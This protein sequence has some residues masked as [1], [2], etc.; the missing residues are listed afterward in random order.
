M[1]LRGFGSDNHA[2]IHPKILEGIL[3]ANRDH[4]AS[5]GTDHL[6]EKTR[7]LFKQ[8]F[9]ADTESFFVFNGT[10]ANVLSFRALLL[11][12]EAIIASDTAHAA[13]DE[14]SAPEFHGGN[15]IITIKSKDGKL[16][17]DLIR[18]VLIR[19]GDQHAAQPRLV[20]LTQPTEWGTVYSL[21]ELA[22]L[23]SFAKEHDLLIHLDG[24]RLA[25][26][27]AHL[28][29]TFRDLVNVAKPAAISFG[30][31]KN[32]LMGAEAVLFFS[33]EFTKNFKYI[34]KQE[35]QLHSKTRF[36]AA[37]LFTYLQDGF[38]Y[39][40][41]QKSLHLAQELA[42]ALNGFPEIEIVQA[43]Q[44]NAVF[45]KIPKNWTKPLKDAA[46]FYMWDE[47]EW[48]A[49]LMLSHD[50]EMEDIHRFTQRIHELKTKL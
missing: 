19:K 40:L 12:H 47:H 21:N 31:T 35:M 7:E 42:T 50:N 14:C 32:G 44:S 24:A 23:S 20:T 46:F 22:E 48:I 16:H 2:T 39:E 8:H 13:V 11:S 6:T 33:P 27:A 4:A 29:C 17:P 3:H 36:L 28:N 43:V 41:A 49:R 10:A 38:C 15:K 5:Y 18:P 34:Q 1:S 37:Q 30:G 25:N 9:G 26:A 45:V